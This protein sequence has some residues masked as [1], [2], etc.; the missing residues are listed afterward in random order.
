MVGICIMYISTLQLFTH[1]GNVLN[2]IILPLCA[3]ADKYMQKCLKRKH[4][5]KKKISTIKIFLCFN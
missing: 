1:F 3:C 5:V 2:C 4:K